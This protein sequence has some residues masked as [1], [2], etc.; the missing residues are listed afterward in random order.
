MVDPPWSGYNRA[1]SLGCTR[2]VVVKKFLP[3]VFV[4][5]LIFF[6]A[7]QPAAASRLFRSIGNLLVT[8]ANGIAAFLANLV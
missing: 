5:F 3:W 7:F 1:L 6:V 4:A 8:V 2:K